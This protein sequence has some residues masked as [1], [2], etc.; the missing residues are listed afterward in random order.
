MAHLQLKNASFFHG[1]AVYSIYLAEFFQRLDAD[2][3]I[4]TLAKNLSYELHRYNPSLSAQE[5]HD[6]MY[7]SDVR[8]DKMGP[9]STFPIVFPDG[10]VIGSGRYLSIHGNGFNVSWEYVD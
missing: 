4:H 6:R 1:T 7:R 9:V 5:Y 10:S 8:K 2:T 3:D